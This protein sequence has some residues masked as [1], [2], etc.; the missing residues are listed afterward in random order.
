MREDL[1]NQVNLNFSPGRL[2]VLNIIL[3][4]F[5]FGVARELKMWHVT[6]MT[7]LNFSLRAGQYLGSRH[8]KAYLNLN[9]Y[10]LFP[11]ILLFLRLPVIIGVYFSPRFPKTTGK[12]SGPIKKASMVIFILFVIVAFSNN[13]KIFIDYIQLVIVVVFLHNSIA[14]ITGYYYGKMLGLS[15][16]NSRT[17]TIES[18]I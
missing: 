18:G 16:L 6:F 13:Y 4:F 8:E 15:T 10:D 3:G 14:I 9:M 11:I 2:I 12:I 7:L 17:I 5:M 1:L